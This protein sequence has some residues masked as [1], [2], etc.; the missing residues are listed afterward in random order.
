MKNLLLWLFLVIPVVSW[1]Q[2]T[3]VTLNVSDA[4]GQTWNNGSYAF[5]FVGPQSVSWSGGTFN[6]NNSITGSLNG[7]GSATVS[8][9]DNNAMSA[10]GTS[11]T[12]TVCAAVFPTQCS[13]T[14]VVITGAAQTVTMTPPTISIS[15][16]TIPSRPL[17]I[18][19]YVDSE[20][21]GGWIGFTYYNL[22]SSGNRVCTAV[23]SNSCSTWA[24][25]SG[26]STAAGVVALFTGCSGVLVLR[27]DGTCGSAGTGNVSTG[28]TNVFGAFLQDFSAS[29]IELPEAAGFVSNVD[30]TIGLDTTANNWHLWGN[31]VDNI[32]VIVP[33][34][35]TIADEHCVDW[36]VIGGVITVDDAGAQG[37]ANCNPV[38]S[39]A[40][41][42]GVVTLTSTDVGLSAVTNDVQTKAAIV[43]NTAPSAGQQLVGNAG[44][45]AYAPVTESG[46][47]TITSAGVRTNTGLNGT[48][49][50][51]LATG[52]LKNTTGTGVPS[53][54]AAPTGAVLGT[55][56]TQVVTNKDLT[57]GTNTFPAPA[58]ASVFGRTGAVVAAANDYT[59]SQITAFTTNPQTS[60]YQ[61]LA[62]DFTACKVIPVASGAFTITLVASGSQPANGQCIWVVNYGVGIVTIARSGQ[63]INGAASNFTLLAAASSSPNVALIV[64]DGTN[65][66]AAILGNA[67]LASAGNI[68]AGGFTL[69]GSAATAANA[70][71]LPVQAGAA[72]TA[73]GAMSYDSTAGLT[74]AAT[75][76]VD[77]TVITAPAR[78]SATAQT[79]A[80]GTA[81]L[82]TAAQCPA[83]TG[84]Y[85]VHWEFTGGGTA[86]SNVSAGSV[87]FL[88]TWTDENA[89]VHSAV[90]LQMQAQTGAATTAMQASFPFQTALANESASGTFSFSSNGSIIQYATGYVACTTGTGTYSV[91]A[92]VT[93]MQ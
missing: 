1:G 8:V 80:I 67:V 57:S 40:G 48:S 36:S 41:R 11:W 79:A 89:V 87:T 88:L 55:T 19:A 93:R 75:N 3:T 44:G 13:S 5:T 4:G 20:I 45:T 90:A 15:V 92:E 37:T 47:S 76:G 68:V 10:T 65:Y 70:F 35:L 52:L 64:S 27:A 50:A 28:Q 25:A 22:V 60:T 21:S 82:C 32:N 53:V 26:V 78:V 34:S 42:T 56:D 73:T 14:T 17:P 49:L 54:V 46:D 61:V 33:A 31:S 74:H 23:T 2:S 84:H 6:P 9:P 77:S 24:N 85:E 16:P 91:R 63:N 59:M 81:T 83:T 38:T 18:R 71:R 7:S 62:S 66:T 29:T 51:G 39:V 58:V 86:C 69:N 72:V 43:P 12:I 30:S